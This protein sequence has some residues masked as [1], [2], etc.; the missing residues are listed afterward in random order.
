MKRGILIFELLVIAAIV[1]LI[2]WALARDYPLF[3]V[4]LTVVSIGCA[5]TSW[6]AARKWPLFVN[7]VLGVVLLFACALL[8][9]SPASKKDHVDLVPAATR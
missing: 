3:A 8:F 6:L 1:G 2:V 7:I 5:I 4:I 9:L